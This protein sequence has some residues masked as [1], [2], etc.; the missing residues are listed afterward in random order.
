[1]VG[2]KIIDTLEIADKIVRQLL[3]VQPGERALLIADTETEMSMVESIAAAIR[4]AGG[5][6]VVAIMPSLGVGEGAHTTLPG[7]LKRALEEADIAI[8]L[9]RTSGAPSYDDT[10]ARLLR[11]R[12][13]RYM[14][15]VMRTPENWTKGAATADYEE[16]HATA[17]RMRDLFT[18]DVCRVTTRLGTDLTSDIRGKRVIIE[19]G[20]ARE[21]GQSSA[22]SDGEVSLG[23]VEG[24]TEG[25]VVV[26]GP[27]AYLGLPDEPVRMEVG[28]GRITEV[29]GGRT[30][31]RVR[32]LLESVPN[33]DNFAEIGIGV[34]PKARRSGDWQEE[35]KRWGN[36][37]IA[38]GDN[39]YYGGTTKCPL[40]S[41]FVVYRPTVEVDGRVIVEEGELK[42]T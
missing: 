34:N 14:S 4:S 33:F 10:V 25:V 40:H 36:V 30:A 20:L 31:E 7:M 38:L 19:A 35:K 12:R 17:R 41:D 21:A 39:I 27:I 28:E 24:T 29:E 15:M 16:V 22:F 26:D 3:A 23:P 32:A 9:N 6:Y 42:L 8:G 1:M 37:H 2:F 18:G 13:I 5:E 11:E